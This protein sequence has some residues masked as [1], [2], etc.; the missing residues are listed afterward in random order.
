MKIPLDFTN[1]VEDAIYLTYL[2]AFDVHTTIPRSKNEF[3]EQLSIGKSKLY[4]QSE[5][6]LLIV[7]ELFEERISILRKLSSVTDKN[8]TYF[9]DD[10]HLQLDNLLVGELFLK[11]LLT[12]SD[13]FLDI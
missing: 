4:S 8:L 5:E 1:F 6:I 11:Q 3:D 13:N 9:C 10:I 12:D 7:D 2:N